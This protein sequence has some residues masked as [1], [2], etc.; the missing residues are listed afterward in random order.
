V[1]LVLGQHGI[2]TPDLTARAFGASTGE[3]EFR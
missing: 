3:L 2:Q 1:G